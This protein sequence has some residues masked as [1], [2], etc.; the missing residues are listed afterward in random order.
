MRKI[1]YMKITSDD[2]LSDK[3]YKTGCF[4]ICL[5]LFIIVYAYTCTQ[6][7]IILRIHVSNTHDT[8][9]VVNLYYNHR[10]QPTERASYI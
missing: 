8:Y 3:K 10:P 2:I 4:L 5:I 1:V 7:N 9:Y 6:F